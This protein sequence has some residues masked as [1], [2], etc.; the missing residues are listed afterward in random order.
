[1][2]ILLGICIP[3]RLGSIECGVAGGGRREGVERENMPGSPGV[4]VHGLLK[5]NVGK[6]QGKPGREGKSSRLPGNEG[7]SFGM[8]GSEGRGLGMP[9][10]DGRGL[11]MPGRNGKG[12]GMP[13]S[14]GNV[15]KSL[16]M[17]DGPSDLGMV[18]TTTNLFFNTVISSSI[19][20]RFFSACFATIQL[21]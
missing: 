5:D 2:F 18:L 14:K 6:L 11:G 7:R 12:L 9:G 15:G 8:P 20:S 16:G 17:P 13:G 4:G 19:S 10:R 21:L 1:M 3:G